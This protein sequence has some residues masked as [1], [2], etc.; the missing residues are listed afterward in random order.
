[1]LPY[2]KTYITQMYKTFIR[3]LSNDNNNTMKPLWNRHFLKRPY[4]KTIFFPWAKIVLRCL[5]LL[6]WNWLLQTVFFYTL[7]ILIK[8]CK[9]Q[10]LNLYKS[11]LFPRNQIFYLKKKAFWRAT[12]TTEFNIFCWNFAHVSYLTISTK[13]CSEFFYFI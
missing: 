8:L 3:V 10:Y 9:I 6:I 7:I 5:A 12:T 13:G 4:S 1:M 11:V 2:W